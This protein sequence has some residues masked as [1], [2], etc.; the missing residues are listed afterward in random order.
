MKSKTNGSRWIYIIL[1]HMHIIS[2]GSKILSPRSLN[3]N[4]YCKGKH[5]KLMSLIMINKYFLIEHYQI[6]IQHCVTEDVRNFH[7]EELQLL[8]LREW[9]LSDAIKHISYSSSKNYLIFYFLFKHIINESRM[10]RYL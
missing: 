1:K 10:F 8:T 4:F 6:Y 2:P 9:L 3:C 5:L 7:N